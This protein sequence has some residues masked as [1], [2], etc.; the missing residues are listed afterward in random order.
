MDYTMTDAKQPAIVRRALETYRDSGA[1]GHVTFPRL[2]VSIDTAGR[3]RLRRW[4]Q[5]PDYAAADI[6]DAVRHIVEVHS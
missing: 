5:A 3:W 4:A 2:F 6:D 1:E